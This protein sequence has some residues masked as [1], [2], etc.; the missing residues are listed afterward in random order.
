MQILSALAELLAPT[1]HAAFWDKYAQVFPI[2]D[3][4][5]SDIA[6]RFQTTFFTLIGGGAVLG[7]FYGALKLA[8]SMG[9]DEGR[10]NA[11]NAVIAAV[12][13]I[14]LAIIGPPFIRQIAAIVSGL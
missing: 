2:R 10:Q 4:S 7:I 11:K 14:I 13:G 1:A 6:G 3:A 9:E 12:F 5:I 8:M